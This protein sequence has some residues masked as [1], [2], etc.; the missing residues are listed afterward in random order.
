[1]T[2]ELK[3]LKG[4]KGHDGE[5]LY[6][7]NIYRYGKKIGEWSDDSWGG[8]MNYHFVSPTEESNFIAHAKIVLA[9]HKDYDGKDYDTATMSS[10]DLISTA[11]FQMSIA[12]IEQSQIKKEVKKGI[13]YYRKDPSDSSGKCMY[14]WCVAYTPENVKA[15]RD[16][17]SDLLEI[18]NETLKMPFEDGEAYALAEKNKR[19]KKLC[20]TGTLFLIK[21]ADGKVKEL[22]GKMPYSSVLAKQLRAK[23]PNLLEI[24]NERYL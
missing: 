14:T 21:E 12:E 7:S 24:V 23:Y 2:I 4:F 20:K 13:V 17:F 18:C 19:Y 11:I 22:V 8:P 6:Q 5:P 3:G 9:S 1:M 10:F 16:K 15:I